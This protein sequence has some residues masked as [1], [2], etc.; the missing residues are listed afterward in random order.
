MVA[1]EPYS[2]IWLFPKIRSGSEGYKKSFSKYNKIKKKTAN[3]FS[4]FSFPK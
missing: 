3:R 2:S 1:G 4:H